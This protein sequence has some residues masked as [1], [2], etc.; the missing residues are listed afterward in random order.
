M[1]Y[2]Y[3][4][5]DRF[6]NYDL[7]HHGIKGMRWGVRRYQNAD[8]SLTD[9]GRRRYGSESYFNAKQTYKDAKRAYSKDF[10]SAYSYSQRHP[11]RLSKKVRDEEKSR[12]DKAYDSGQL[13][14]NSRKEYK[15]EKTK[16]KSQRHID[17]IS[18]DEENIMRMRAKNEER[19]K[20]KYAKKVASGKMSKEIADAKL[21][22]F[23]DG[24]PL[25]KNGYARY[26]KMVSDY[27]NARISALSDPAFK[28][29]K[30]YKDA[31][32]GYALLRYLE[33]EYGGSKT[34]PALYYTFED[35]AE[36]EK[37]KK[38]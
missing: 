13:V 20:N 16:F 2:Y 10:D 5:A 24:T 37:Q 34:C 35:I 32:K 22:N 9:L 8:G 36:K 7:S 25:V 28:K 17:A 4:A 31:M 33:I 21:K 29:T 30:T 11:I 23:T 26:K 3:I 1:S 15:K 19:L 6:G 14:R 27:S 12:W 38:K 18:R